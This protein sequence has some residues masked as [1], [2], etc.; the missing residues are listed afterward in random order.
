MKNIFKISVLC[1]LVVGCFANKKNQTE[2]D[3]LVFVFD[4]DS[5]VVKSESLEDVVKLRV[6]NNTKKVKKLEE[7]TNLGMEGKISFKDSVIQRLGLAK[8]DKKSINNV[9][10]L[11]IK[12]ITP[13]VVE[14]IDKI[15]SKGHKVVIVSGS[16]REL[17]LPVARYLKIEDKDVFA[18]EFLFK[19]NYV[20]SAKESF[21]L[22]SDGKVV[23]IENIRKKET[24]N[25]QKVKIIM[26]GDGYNDL[27]TYTH[28]AS[29]VFIAFAV[30]KNR[31]VVQKEAKVF[32][33]T[34]EEFKV[35]VEKLL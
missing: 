32:V 24:N 19:G 29:D 6:G 21:M 34:I 20:V 25:N 17:L 22:S 2:R 35:E 5:T 10:N 9:A 31:D 15:R 7:I 8:L 26:I 28:K 14:V 3:K 30:N 1:F 27:L 33:K 11:L 13:G 16:F 4:F 18:N 12:D 23:A